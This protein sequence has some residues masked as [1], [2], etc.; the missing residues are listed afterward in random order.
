MSASRPTEASVA[1][2]RQEAARLKTRKD[3]DA[4]ATLGERLPGEVSGPWLALADDV[5]LALGQRQRF[6]EAIRLLEKTWAAEPTHRRAAALAYLHYSAL[7]QRGRDRPQAREPLREGFRRWI[8]EALRLRPGSVKDLYRLGVFE[9]QVESQRDKV[10]LRA[11]L[12]AIRSYHEMPAEERER[13]HDLRKYYVKSLYA[14]GRSALR[15]RNTGLARRLSFECIR[16]DRDGRYVDPVHSLGL[17]G[18]V[19]LANGELDHAE[20]AFRLALDARG[21]ARRDYLYGFLAETCRRRGA[22]EDAC[23]WIEAHVRPER[24]SAWLWRL[25]GDIRRDRADLDGALSAYES[26]LRRDRS[27]RHLTLT[28]IGD[29]HRSRQRWKQAERAYRQALE[30]RRRRYLSDHREALE[31]LDAVLGARGKEAERS[32]V[33]AQ[34]RELLER[35]VRRGPQAAPQRRPRAVREDAG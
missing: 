11:F 35:G 7:M 25:L 9:A 12:G 24:R 28:R 16:A 30:F 5:A 18:K 31:G 13:R 20:R 22:L 3:W 6:P 33:R 29:I 21:P 27:G 1:D 32:E 4:L 10:A 15:L 19:C 14:G 17:A 26:A 23:R 2:L 8:G 34:L